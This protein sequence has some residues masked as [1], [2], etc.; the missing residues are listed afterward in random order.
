MISMKNILIFVK[1]W[2]FF[3]KWKG[4]KYFFRNENNPVFTVHERKMPTLSDTYS[5]TQILL[6]LLDHHY[7]CTRKDHSAR[8]VCL[9]TRTLELGQN[10][11]GTVTLV[12]SVLIFQLKI[13][14]VNIS[15][16]LHLGV[17]HLVCF[18]VL[19]FVT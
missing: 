12:Y 9:F 11:R 2:G 17:S 14:D 3:P 6:P 16:F 19:P 13:N 7:S 1:F 8:H 10:G 15:V 4:R 5:Y 18:H